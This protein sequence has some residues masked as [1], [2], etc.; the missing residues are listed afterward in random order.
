MPLDVGVRFAGTLLVLASRHLRELTEDH[1]APIGQVSIEGPTRMVNWMADT[2]RGVKIAIIEES[3]EWLFH[4]SLA[5]A[6]AFRILRA[7]GAL[8]P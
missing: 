4:S 5:A 7:T 6:L 8:A 1:S 3:V 2:S